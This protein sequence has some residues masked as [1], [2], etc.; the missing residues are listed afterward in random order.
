MNRNSDLGERVKRKKHYLSQKQPSLKTPVSPVG[1]AERLTVPAGGAIVVVGIVVLVDG[2]VVL[3]GGL[4]SSVFVTV[5]IWSATGSKIISG[6]GINYRK[7][8]RSYLITIVGIV[9]QYQ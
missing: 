9:H 3:G 1:A 2:I 4:S 6:T 8:Q 7:C 5:T